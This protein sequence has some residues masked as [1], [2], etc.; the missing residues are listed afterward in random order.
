MVSQAH[1]APHQQ[2]GGVGEATCCTE[3]LLC[4]SWPTDSRL[5]PA[6]GTLLVPS[7][8]SETDIRLLACQ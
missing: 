7:Y 5:A 2:Q 6:V 1:Q 3:F 8:P 4:T